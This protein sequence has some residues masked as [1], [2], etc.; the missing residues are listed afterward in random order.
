MV[1]VPPRVRYRPDIT[2]IIVAVSNR[3][4]WRKHLSRLIS[5]QL[6]KILVLSFA[7]ACQF[8]D[9]VGAKKTAKNQ[10]K[11]SA[12]QF[13]KKNPRKSND[14]QSS[15]N[16]PKTTLTPRNPPEVAPFIANSYSN[17]FIESYSFQRSASLAILAS[18]LLSFFF[19]PCLAPLRHIF[20]YEVLPAS[21]K[22]SSTPSI[23]R[24]QSLSKPFA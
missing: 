12:K 7:L 8:L 24:S 2:S 4:K 23:P 22:S 20:T 18:N 19:S 10:R 9:K 13:R 11:K 3:K 17:L 5:H 1:F 16:S 14:P 15:Q 6:K 21:L